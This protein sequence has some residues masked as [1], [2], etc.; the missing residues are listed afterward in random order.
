ME[1]SSNQKEKPGYIYKSFGLHKGGSLMKPLGPIL[2]ILLRA[3]LVADIE[4][5]SG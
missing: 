3:A 4:F 2:T 1:I 5:E